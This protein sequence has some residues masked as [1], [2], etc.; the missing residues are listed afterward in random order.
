MFVP[1]LSTKEKKVASPGKILHTIQEIERGVI[2]VSGEK[3]GQPIT[4][5]SAIAALRA[6]LVDSE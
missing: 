3:D 6:K 2:V 1:T 4:K 5:E